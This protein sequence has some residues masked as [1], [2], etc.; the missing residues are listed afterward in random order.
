MEQLLYELVNLFCEWL[1]L[2][3]MSNLLSTNK[4]FCQLIRQNH[5]YLFCKVPFLR[6]NDTYI[7]KLMKR[8]N[9]FRRFYLSYHK[10]YDTKLTFGNACVDGYLSIAK[11]LIQL[12]PEINI[13]SYDN[14]AFRLACDGGYLEIAK[15]L[16]TFC[17]DYHIIK[18][19]PDI[20]W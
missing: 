8:F 9:Y 1:T 15:W 17:S 16:K 2:Q 6:N 13:L 18:E 12:F 3:E 19:S 14:Y 5:F 10:K 20:I 4:Y 11:W 7:Y